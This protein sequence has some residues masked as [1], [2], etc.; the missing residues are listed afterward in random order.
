MYPGI[1]PVWNTDNI[2]KATRH[3]S[4]KEEEKYKFSALAEGILD[5]P[6]KL[7]CTSTKA[8][9]QLSMQGDYNQSGTG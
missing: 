3:S 8:T 9:A 2:S 6:C 1:V 5:S 4:I 7:P